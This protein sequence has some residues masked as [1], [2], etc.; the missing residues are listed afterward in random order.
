MWGWVFAVLGPFSELLKRRLGI[1]SDGIA[2]DIGWE[3]VK[4]VGIHRRAIDCGQLS[5]QWLCRHSHTTTVVK[6]WAERFYREI[7]FSDRLG[8]FMGDGIDQAQMVA[9]V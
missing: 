8:D 9:K 1:G 7:L 2:D 5:C 3:P 6:V 4:N